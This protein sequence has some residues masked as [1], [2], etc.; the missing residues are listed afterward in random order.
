MKQNSEG[1]EESGIWNEEFNRKGAVAGAC[2]VFSLIDG[3][4]RMSA[5]MFETEESG[6]DF[7]CQAKVRS[8]KYLIKCI[9]RLLQFKIDGNDGVLMLMDLCT[10]LVQWRHQ[11]REVFQGDKDLDDVINALTHELSSL[12]GIL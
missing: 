7:I 5:S 10:R 2:L 8:C 4:E 9:K 6:L 1:L 11:G 3:I 12:S